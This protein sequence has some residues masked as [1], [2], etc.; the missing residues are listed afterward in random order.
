MMRDSEETIQRVLTGL[1]DVE[2]PKGMERRIVDA[3]EYRASGLAAS[4]ASGS[5]PFR[6]PIPARL[7]AV[8]LWSGSIAVAGV[9][10]VSLVIAVSNHGRIPTPPKTRATASGM[11]FQVARAGVLQAVHS[12][13]TDPSARIRSATP[14][15][16]VRLKSVHDSASLTET[17]AASHPAPIAPLTQEEK[18]L[19]RIAHRGNPEEL[20]MLNP[21]V[22]AQRDAESEAEFLKF[23]DE[24]TK[25]DSE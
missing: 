16:K 17:R 18:L 11:S 6:L 21:Q 14:S 13:S 20:A 10:A 24:S 9:M 1:R 22:Q 19:L 15:L 7:S 12:P 2:A 4:N 8:Q 25:G 3:L 23:V 5:K